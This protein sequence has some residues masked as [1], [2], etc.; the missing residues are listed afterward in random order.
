MSN[1]K[2]D[3]TGI[4][5]LTNGSI[6]NKKSGESSIRWDDE[7]EDAVPI[8]IQDSQIEKLLG[9][10]KSN[11]RFYNFA[12]LYL[13]FNKNAEFE[14]ENIGFKE[15][16]LADIEYFL[17]KECSAREAKDLAKLIREDFRKQCIA[18]G[19]LNW[20]SIS[21]R[22]MKWFK[23]KIFGLDQYNIRQFTNLNGLPLIQA[24]IDQWE[25]RGA[26]K[27]NFVSELQKKWETNIKSDH[28]LS[29]LEDAK[30]S[31]SRRNLAWNELCEKHSSKFKVDH[32]PKSHQD[33]L[34]I[35]DQLVEEGISK[36]VFVRSLQNKL[37][38]QKNAD[39]GRKPK[40]LDILVENHSRLKR[41]ATSWKVTE[42][43]AMDRLISEAFEKE[44]PSVD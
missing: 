26:F 9:E 19:A 27:A 29:W 40:N 32:A 21:T 33:V 41:L 8:V 31:K 5:F 14:K 1:H 16:T 12:W 11:M 28:E 35:F 15:A 37:S 44:A 7:S 25:A 4:E 38:K 30:N 43:E 3:T 34:E 10:S 6:L 2:I 13:F 20:I 42:R 23:E 22:P 24:I 17:D 18:A 36:K 39:N